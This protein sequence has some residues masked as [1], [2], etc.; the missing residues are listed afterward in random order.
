VGFARTSSLHKGARIRDSPASLDLQRRKEGQERYTD[1]WKVDY[2]RYDGRKN[3]FAPGMSLFS[4]G[5]NGETSLLDAVI[6]EPKEALTEWHRLVN[7]YT[8]RALTV[9]SDRVLAIS[10]IAERYGKL[11]PSGYRAGLWRFSLPTQLLWS[12][13]EPLQRRPDKYQAPSWSWMSINGAVSPPKSWFREEREGF[14]IEVI[15]CFVQL[16][17]SSAP[18]GAVMSG[19]LKLRGRTR[20]AQWMRSLV[21]DRKGGSTGNLRERNIE[22]WTGNLAA[23]IEPD[24][25]E[26]DF[27]DANV[28]SLPV[29][30][31][32]VWYPQQ[33]LNC[34]PV[35]LILREVG[36]S[37]FQR[38]G[39][40]T[41]KVW[42]MVLENYFEES[43]DQV[44]ELWHNK[45]H[46]F[47]TCK[48]QTIR[49][50]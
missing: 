39:V 32:E 21:S 23:V 7:A 47:D 30:L 18:Y 2:S 45:Q 35:G 34:G 14:R 17:R 19:Y 50:I 24:A 28:E 3:P 6:F 38:L 26:D 22:G 25:L 5:S 48:Q 40:F 27:I 31:L 20:P 29:V 4:R 43:G 8:S 33:D 12:A 44:D 36:A 1:G 42:F 46:W 10:G 41:F 15:D 49:I 13:I 11:F 37:L 9:P 16:L